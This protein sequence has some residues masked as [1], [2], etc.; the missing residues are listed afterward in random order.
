MDE[1]E[2]ARIQQVEKDQAKLMEEE[3]KRKSLVE[4][5]EQ[6]NDRV[7]EPFVKPVAR[8]PLHNY[9]GLQYTGDVYFGE[10]PQKITA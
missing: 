2:V 5:I 3:S 4:V 1:E 10:P 9:S 7:I 6:E 8:V